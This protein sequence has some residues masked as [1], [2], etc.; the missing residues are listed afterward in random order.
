MFTDD[1]VVKIGWLKT[2]KV[3]FELERM[4]LLDRERFLERDVPVLLIGARQAL[5]GAVPQP[6]APEPLL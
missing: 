2:L 1:G 4:R 3:S 6:V 5:R